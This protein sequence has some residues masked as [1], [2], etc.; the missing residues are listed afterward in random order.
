MNA[1]STAYTTVLLITTSMP[2]RPAIRRA[3]QDLARP[4]PSGWVPWALA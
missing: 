3:S 2:Y 4:A 1:A